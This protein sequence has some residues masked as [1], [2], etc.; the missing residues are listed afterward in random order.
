MHEAPLTVPEIDSR[1]EMAQD[2]IER[3]L[4]AKSACKPNA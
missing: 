2:R 1:G 4:R 3:A